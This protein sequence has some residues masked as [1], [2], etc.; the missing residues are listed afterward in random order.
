MKNAQTVKPRKGTYKPAYTKL[1][2][3]QTK[4]RLILTEELAAT[5]T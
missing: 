4:V 3:Q 1:E 2:A 5:A